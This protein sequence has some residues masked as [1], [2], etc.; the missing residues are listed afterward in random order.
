MT[1]TAAPDFAHLKS[2]M[3]SMWTAGD[4]GQIANYS[5]HAGVEFVAR[6]DIRAGARVLDVACGT[7][8]VSLPAA[9]AGATVT[10]VDIAP[11]LLDQARKRASAENLS[12]RFD[13]GD[14]EDLPYPEAEFDI[15]LTMFGAMF[16][17]RP[18]KT[19]AELIRVCRPGGLIAMANWTP[20]GFVGKT[21]QLTAKIAPPPPGVVPSVLW[22]DEATV[23]QRFSQGISKLTLTRHTVTFEYPFSPKEVV[24]FFRQYFGPTQ[25]TFARLDKAN[26]EL[27]ASELETAWIENNQATDGTTK[28]EAEYLDVRAIRA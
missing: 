11:N 4:F 9:R 22:G 2:R 17:P 28:V 1:Q 16:A 8:N 26:Q 5:A 6:T 10:G 18:E 3:K 21:F 13:E 23:K 12:I 20:Q 25:T 7:G 19:A 14:A 24:A 15:V 27:L